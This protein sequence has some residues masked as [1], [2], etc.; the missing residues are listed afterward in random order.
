MNE[1]ENGHN[2]S[3][4]GRAQLSVRDEVN[5]AFKRTG[6]LLFGEWNLDMESL[7][8]YLHRYHYPVSRRR[9]ADGEIV[10]LA[11]ERYCGGAKISRYDPAAQ[12]AA[13]FDIN[14]IKDLDSLLEGVEEVM[15]Y[16]GNKV[17]GNSARVE[18]CDDITD[19]AFCYR[20]H[21]ISASKYMGYSSYMRD[22]SECAFGTSY[23]LRSRHLIKAISGDAVTRAFEAYLCVTSSDIYCSYGCMGCGDMMFC[24]NQ[25]AKRHMIGNLQLERGKYTELKKKL[26]AEMREYIEKHKTFPS[27]FDVQDTGRPQLGK[28]APAPRKVA[29]SDFGRIDSEF[30]ATC[31]IIF[32]AEIGGLKGLE[33]YLE[34]RIGRVREVETAFGG[35]TA[36][37]DFM[38]YP[39]VKPERMVNASESQA[40][41]MICLGE[42]ELASLGKILEGLPKIAYVRMEFHEGTVENN[43]ETVIAYNSMNTYRVA[44]ATFSK[45]CA[46]D[47]M[48]LNCE[49][50][51]GCF[52]AVHSKFSIKCHYCVNVSGCFELESCSNC[53]A[54]LFCHNC[55]NLSECMFCF[56]AKGLRYAIGNVEVG[57]EEYTRVK[58]I[59][60]AD[61]AKTLREKKGLG[62]DIYDV[63]C[64]ARKKGGKIARAILSGSAA[65][66]P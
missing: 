35:R 48:A 60:M 24:F 58:R 51:Y 31:R 55:E 66:G 27:I 6:A 12:N 3:A 15:G 11:S 36:S 41:A 17:F 19:S 10:G 38:Y 4:G 46:C 26:C 7:E 13:H 39:S 9:G 2:A 62:M 61:I 44:D 59:V 45:N 1:H 40:L 23:L 30:R 37:P 33:E 63:A 18:E 57:R 34:S 14:S 16:C 43:P 54:S 50:V 29:V 49:N 8:G 21:S 64:R 56:N 32:G 20:S 25:K 42:G 52:R 28:N 47:T 22:N 65:A 5:A 53:S